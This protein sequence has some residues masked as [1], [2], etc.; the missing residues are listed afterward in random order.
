MSTLGHP[1]S[2]VSSVWGR[3]LVLVAVLSLTISL[4]GRYTTDISAASGTA[5]TVAAHQVAG[6]TQHL[7]GDGLQW[8][9][10]TT[11]LLMMVVPRRT[12][13]ITPIP[14]PVIELYSEDWLYNRPPPLA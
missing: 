8:T 4:A 13:R 9:A 10:P 7:L 14:L 1:A 5:T 11:A 3:L 6:K 12:A 2:G